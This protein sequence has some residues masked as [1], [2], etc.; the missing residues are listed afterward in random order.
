MITYSTS[1]SLSYFVYI[2][3]SWFLSAHR[4]HS[5]TMMDVNSE[6]SRRSNLQESF[7]WRYILFVIFN[8]TIHH[9][10]NITFFK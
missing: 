10:E 2:S 1:E 3:V 7:N 6:I 5:F 9:L 4:H 8:F